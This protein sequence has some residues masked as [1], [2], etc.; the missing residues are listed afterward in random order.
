MG[1]VVILRRIEKPKCTV[2]VL[3]Q[4]SAADRTR[5]ESRIENHTKKKSAVPFFRVLS[6]AAKMAGSGQRAGPPP[7]GLQQP[8]V[9]G[10]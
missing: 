10:S 3:T 7:P 4:T 6:F 8:N 1:F 9:G 5:V 2:L